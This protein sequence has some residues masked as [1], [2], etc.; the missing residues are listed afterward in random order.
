M[1][2][3]LLDFFNIISIIFYIVTISNENLFNNY[4]FRKFSIL[5]LII[6]L[7]N[8]IYNSVKKYKI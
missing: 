3:K 8:I 1:K 5:F 4:Y 6:T 2:Q 7:L